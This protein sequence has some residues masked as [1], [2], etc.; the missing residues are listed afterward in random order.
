[1]RRDDDPWSARSDMSEHGRGGLLFAAHRI[2]SREARP[3]AFAGRL[4]GVGAHAGRDSE[5]ILG[6]G[7]AQ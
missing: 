6:A 5:M 3:N 2:E 1:M 4:G 7:D